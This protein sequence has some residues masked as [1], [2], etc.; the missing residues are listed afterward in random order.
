MLD[1]I[2]EKKD[3]LKQLLETKDAVI[4]FIKSHCFTDFQEDKKLYLSQLEE[5]IRHIE[6]EIISLQEDYKKIES[7]RQYLIRMEKKE[8][9]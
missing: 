1:Q 3:F 6:N 8:I 9:W 2:K 4:A 5:R 7:F